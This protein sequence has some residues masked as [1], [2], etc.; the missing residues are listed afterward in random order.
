MSLSLILRILAKDLRLGPRSPIFLYA[1]AFPIILTLLVV[2]VFGS[3]FAPSPRLGVLDAGNSS[4]TSKIQQVDGI[5][6]T[7]FDS[8]DEL[9]E[10]VENDNLDAGLILQKDF[11]SS[12]IAQERP[13]LQFYVGGN[14]LLS[15]RTILAVTTI[16]LIREVGGS[17]GKV[18]V[19]IE[20]LGTEES[21]P[22]VDRLLPMLLIY[23]VIIAG[24]FVPASSIVAERESGT[25]SALM[26][27]PVQIP[28]IMIAKGAMGF[29]LAM[30]AG[31]VTLI[32]NQAFG[33][34]PLALVLILT[35]ASAMAVT[36]GLIFGS[37]AKDANSLFTAV[38]GMG[39]FLFAPVI[40]FIWPG[41][42]Q[43]IGQLFPT[44]YFLF[45]LFE[46]GVKGATLA[47]VGA[48]LLIGFGITAVFAV[49][50]AITARRLRS[51]LSS[52]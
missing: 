32:I 38:K 21:I 11:D 34:A 39:I 18:D 46:V 52:T 35:L 23:A 9:I 30:L 26:V 50:A 24:L 27:S 8:E 3:L 44:Y 48:E 1:I 45:P 5:T 25:L 31:I 12:L 10:Q 2:F 41:L 16:D 40:F 20:K 19:S 49:I 13:V 4:I 37:L 15:N 43:W 42:P 28:D 47:D 29:I 6:V 14:S 22:L 33:N 51:V 36:F 7:I 17:T